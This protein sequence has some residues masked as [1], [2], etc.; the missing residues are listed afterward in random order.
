MG[1]PNNIP[2]GNCILIA[3]N[4]SNVWF[5]EELFEHKDI[6]NTMFLDLTML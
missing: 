6:K 5:I 2:C 1:M 3:V 4:P